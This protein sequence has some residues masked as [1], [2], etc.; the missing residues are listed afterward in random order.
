M[1]S[2]F[3]I[4]AVLV[5][6]TFVYA[7]APT[8][9]LGQV[10]DEL[11]KKTGQKS[12]DIENS[13]FGVQFDRPL[14][15]KNGQNYLDAFQDLL[16]SQGWVYEMRGP[17]IY[18]YDKKVRAMGDRHP[19]NRTISSLKLT[20]V[21]VKECFKEIGKQLHLKIYAGIDNDDLSRY[22]STFNIELKNITLR[23][24]IFKIVSTSGCRNWDAHTSTIDNV[25][26]LYIDMD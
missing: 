14:S 8:H 13:P 4:F 9:T 26:S 25:E 18:I 15:V 2:F 5:F 10:I 20:N 6:A 19:L 17:T 23:E 11:V 22:A 3:G 1:K 7:S 24:A 12:F 16:G 21:S